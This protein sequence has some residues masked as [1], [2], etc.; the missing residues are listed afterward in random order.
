M[1][2]MRTN[3]RLDKNNELIMQDWQVKTEE[4]GVEADRIGRVLDR[5]GLTMSSLSQSGT[6]SLKTLVDICRTLNIRHAS[7]T[8]ILLAM[9]SLVQERMR[10]DG[11]R[12]A[13]KHLHRQLLTRTTSHI[14]RA[15]ELQKTLDNMEKDAVQ[16]GPE[17]EKKASQAEFL[18][19]KAREYRRTVD[20]LQ[21]ELTTAGVEPSIYHRTLLTK[22]EDL[23]DLKSRLH[24]VQCKL[25]SY[26]ALPP[27][28]S[29]AKVKVEETKQELTELEAE[30]AQHIDLMHI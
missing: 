26:H 3:E 4:Y 11:L 15:A 10:V 12:L 19:R 16:L 18:Q 5:F 9:S 23:K 6:V 28:L 14:Q 29:L 24:T 20:Q 13:E 27:D 7:D 25:D 30:L 21:K 8:D 1:D 17:M 22:S 2:L